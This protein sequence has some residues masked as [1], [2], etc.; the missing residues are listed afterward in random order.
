M[1]LE[2]RTTVVGVTSTGDG[3]CY[4]TNVSSRVDTASALDF[5]AGVLK[6]N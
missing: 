2:G 5:L 1:E 3:A 6:A 4:A